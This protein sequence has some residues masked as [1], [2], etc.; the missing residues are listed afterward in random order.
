MEVVG[1]WLDVVGRRLDVVGCMR[2]LVGGGWS[3]MIRLGGGWL[4][5]GWLVEVVS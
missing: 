4:E 3:A 5:N 2:W 1:G